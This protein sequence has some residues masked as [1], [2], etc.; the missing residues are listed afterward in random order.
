MN[1]DG[2]DLKKIEQI[3]HKVTD[4]ALETK[5]R[6]MMREVAADVFTEGYNKLIKPQFDDL[7][8]KFNEIDKKQDKILNILDG[9]AS[10]YQAVR[11]EEAAGAV[12]LSSHTT[13]LQEQSD[14]LSD[15]ETRISQL[16]V[17]QAEA[18]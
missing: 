4:N 5:G 13:K 12:V 15:H 7:N 11:E 6:Q 2:K 10:D 8:K 1:L 14:Q 17:V 3:S 16:E 18:A 9:L